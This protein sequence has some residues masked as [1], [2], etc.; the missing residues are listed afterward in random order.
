MTELFNCVNT[1]ILTFHFS[2]NESKRIDAKYLYNL[3]VNILLFIFL[4][5]RFK[6]TD[7]YVPV[8]TRFLIK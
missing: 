4:S 5:V 8:K 1:H 7:L 3:K 2:L 6:Y